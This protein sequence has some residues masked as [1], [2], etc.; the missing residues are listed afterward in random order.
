MRD[1]NYYYCHTLGKHEM[2]PVRS[3]GDQ[4]HNTVRELEVRRFSAGFNL[5]VIVDLLIQDMKED[6]IPLMR[7]KLLKKTH[8]RA[9]RNQTLARMLFKNVEDTKKALGRYHRSYTYGAYAANNSHLECRPVP[10]CWRYDGNWTLKEAV[11]ELD[12]QQR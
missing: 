5:E 2:T 1:G 7:L 8:C 3:R 10:G 12:L 11:E 9:G 6:G 4:T